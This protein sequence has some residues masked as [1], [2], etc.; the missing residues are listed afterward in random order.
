MKLRSLLLTIFIL[1]AS[2][3]AEEI[4]EAEAP[5]SAGIRAYE[6]A[7][8]AAAD[9]A[10]ATAIADSESAAAHHN[11]ALALFQQAQPGEAAWHLER[12]LLLAPANDT[13]HYKLGILRQQLS[14]SAAPPKWYA[15][16]SQALSPAG[17]ILLLCLAGWIA[18]AAYWLPRAARCPAN[19]QIKVL[20]ILGLL[21][22]LTAASALGLNRKLPD[23]GI[24]LSA[25]PV[26][27][28]AAPAAAAPQTGLGR[29]GERAQQIDQHG[30]YLQ[31]ETEGGARGW[32]HNEAF[33]LLL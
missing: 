24:V 29:P 19:L 6:N 2:A 30:H 15:L 25:T 5:F 18:L 31:I 11:R 8:Y 20:R 33:R 9:R 13:Y 12:A 17:W 14:L 21:G 28:H 4:T 27:L 10:F 1:T 23:T 22:L 3:A 7:D 32:I 16:A 26:P